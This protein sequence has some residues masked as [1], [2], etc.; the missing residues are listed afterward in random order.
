MYFSPKEK[1]D[2]VLIKFMKLKY[3]G[4]FLL[5]IAGVACYN[6][7]DAQKTAVKKTNNVVKREDISVNDTMKRVFVIDTNGVG[8]KQHP[9]STSE[10]VGSYSFGDSF[11]VVQSQNGW[12]AIR[13]DTTLRF[14]R[15]SATGDETDIPLTNQDLAEVFYEGDDKPE[16][17]KNIEITL[18]TKKKFYAMKKSS[19]NYFINDTNIIKK[20]NGLIKLPLKKGFER[21]RDKAHE[22][23]N[24]YEGQYP[25]LNKYLMSFSN[26]EAEDTNYEFI[27]KTTGKS[28]DESFSEIPDISINKKKIMCI[29]ANYYSNCAE[30]AEYILGKNGSIKVYSFGQF[31][32]WMPAQSK[33]QFWG[34]DNC[35]YIQVIPS[36]IYN[37][38]YNNLHSTTTPRPD[39]NLR[40]IKI[41]IKGPTIIPKID[42]P[43]YRGNNFGEQYKLTSTLTYEAQIKKI[44][45]ARQEILTHLNNFTKIE[46]TDVLE[47]NRFAY[48]KDKELN[49]VKWVV[50]RNDSEIDHLYYYKNNEVICETDAAKTIKT[51]KITYDEKFYFFDGGLFAW[52]QFNKRIDPNSDQF[53]YVKANTPR[54][55]VSN[56]AHQKH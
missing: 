26:Y 15:Q 2:S 52:L 17:Y 49:L 25:L 42:T 39:Y 45:S 9:D 12:L 6:P 51:G 50:N 54:D 23:E 29:K 4:M 8:I 16:P 33:G 5:L 43:Y 38:H 34:N 37:W 10:T 19:I 21:Y 28:S 24:N 1:T 36:I 53:E 27:D 11:Q 47:G 32:N 31:K 20:H 3:S 55:E 14:V 56:W 41:K 48:W 13:K 18:V 40:Y 46:M 35:Y 30:F 7:V 44:D 22:Y